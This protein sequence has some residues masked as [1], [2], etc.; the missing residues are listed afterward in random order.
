ML[1]VSLNRFALL[2]ILVEDVVL[3]KCFKLLQ[4]APPLSH[5]LANVHRIPERLVPDNKR[6]Q[7][8]ENQ[9]KIKPT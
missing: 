2:G 1:T 3:L 4:K 9:R 5:L 6:F 7:A 8:E